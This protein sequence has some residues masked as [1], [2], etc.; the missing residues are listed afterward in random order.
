MVADYFE[1]GLNQYQKMKNKIPRTINPIAAIHNVLKEG[2]DGLRLISPAST[3][4]L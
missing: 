3:L 2:R 4:C 1:I